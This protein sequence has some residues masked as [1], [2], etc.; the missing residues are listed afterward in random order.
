MRKRFFLS[1]CIILMTCLSLFMS[2]ADGNTKKTTAEE[3]LTVEKL[4]ASPEKYLGRTVTVSGYMTNMG[5]YSGGFGFALY[6]KKIPGK[7]AYTKPVIGV[8][9]NVLERKDLG[10]LFTM[11]QMIIDGREES[12]G[13]IYVKGVLEKKG[14]DYEIK[15]SEFPTIA[16]LSSVKLLAESA[17]SNNHN[18]SAEAIEEKPNE[19]DIIDD[20]G[21]KNLTLYITADINRS[22]SPP[23]NDPKNEM[24]KLAMKI[25]KD[26]IF[27]KKILDRTNKLF[28]EWGG[29][30]T[31]KHTA[32]L[33]VTL[34][35]YRE[36]DLR[37]SPTGRLYIAKGIVAIDQVKAK[38]GFS[39]NSC[40][41][42]AFYPHE[43]YD[44][45]LKNCI[46]LTAGHLV[47]YFK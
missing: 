42:W 19:N 3:N 44:E 36:N 20:Y 25:M 17:E 16:D 4:M 15:I 27:K 21:V 18:T 22:I 46:D 33:H 24:K 9:T 5:Q 26:Q 14:K 31:G 41:K 2:Y 23:P 13:F 32:L 6:N 11:Q 34:D 40:S 12:E 29:K 45:M 39:T 10:R 8:D 43:E 38:S 47:E 28:G 30:I 37:A 1:M 35:T 7:P